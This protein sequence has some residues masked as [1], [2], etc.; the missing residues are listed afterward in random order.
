MNNNNYSELLYLVIDG[1]ANAVEKSTVFSALSN[2]ADLQEEFYDALQ[3]RAVAFNDAGSMTPPAFI[4]RNILKAAGVTTA[5]GALT[6]SPLL[7]SIAKVL[8][9]LFGA[10]LGALLTFV[11]MKSTNS[12][13][14]TFENKQ[15]AARSEQTG[16][17]A[18][19]QADN[20]TIK[21]M[22]S[23]IPTEI[24]RQSEPKII[25]R[26]VYVPVERFI[27]SEKLPAVSS[28]SAT[29][30]SV[31]KQLQAAEQDPS[32]SVPQISEVTDD[33]LIR[34]NGNTQTFTTITADVQD[35]PRVDHS[36][37]VPFMLQMNGIQDFRTYSANLRV[38]Q[39]RAFN[40]ISASLFYKLSDNSSLSCWV[41]SCHLFFLSP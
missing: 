6:S 32:S 11:I 22:A 33:K 29:E 1:E 30:P 18:I 39:N 40:N 26:T 3:M 25:T 34:A 27:N 15:A 37:K 8:P 14:P 4:G 28:L 23:E 41:I 17:S 19:K 31:Q 2:D 12:D 13:I 10:A 20:S 21:Q 24:T 9:S 36:D 5:L 38:S 7:T 16:N 35:S